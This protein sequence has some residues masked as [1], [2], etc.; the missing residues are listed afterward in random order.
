MLTKISSNFFCLRVINIVLIQIICILFVA[1]PAS[2]AVNPTQNKTGGAVQES[3]QGGGFFSNMASTA[4]GVALGHTMGHAI[5]GG[6]GGGQQGAE[7]NQQQPSAPLCQMELDQFI[8]CSNTQRDLTLCNNDI[9][10]QCKATHGL[11]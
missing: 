1:R 9:Y 10:K 2:T 11:I 6:G 7:Q 5:T 8:S 4:A 3:R